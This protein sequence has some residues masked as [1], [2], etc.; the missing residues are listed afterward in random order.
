MFVF[1]YF[2]ESSFGILFFIFVYLIG[3]WLHDSKTVNT[4][5]LVSLALVILIFALY[6]VFEFDE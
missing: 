4:F 6:I 2:T 1:K 5:S 3:F